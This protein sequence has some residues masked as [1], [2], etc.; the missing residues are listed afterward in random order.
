MLKPASAL[1]LIM[2]IL[3]TTPSVYVF[4]TIVARWERK[5]HVVGFGVRVL[6]LGFR[7][8]GVGGGG[9]PRNAQLAA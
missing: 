5:S 4:V 2:G 8:L 1:T 7:V 9:G 6:G 3:C